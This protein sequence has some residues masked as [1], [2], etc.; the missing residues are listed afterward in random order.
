MTA[1]NLKLLAIVMKAVVKQWE[2]P[3]AKFL[4]LSSHVKMCLIT[5]EV[6]TSSKD[7]LQERCI[8]TLDRLVIF[9]AFAHSI[10]GKAHRAWEQV[11][12][13]SEIQFGSL[14]DYYVMPVDPNSYRAYKPCGTTEFIPCIASLVHG[15]DSFE[16]LLDGQTELN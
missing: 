1:G 13:S 4:E 2:D 7:H 12:L 8:Q 16:A 11:W 15:F 10:L 3:F 5:A 9:H 14:L 6:V